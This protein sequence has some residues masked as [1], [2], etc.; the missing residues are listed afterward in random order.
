MTARNTNPS[1]REIVVH[2]NFH[3][4]LNSL[5]SKEGIPGADMM[6][7]KLLR[8]WLK[9]NE[10]SLKR[11]ILSNMYRPQPL[12]SF[13]V[14]DCVRNVPSYID[15]L[16]QESIVNV[17]AAHFEPDF[18]NL[19]FAR[20]DRS[21]NQAASFLQAKAAEF[22]DEGYTLAILPNTSLIY[23]KFEHEKLMDIL[24]NKIQDKAVQ[25]LIA[26]ILCAPLNVTGTVSDKV[27]VGLHQRSVL[28]KMLVNLVLDEIDKKLESNNI[29]FV[30]LL[31]KTV[32]FA[33]SKAEAEYVYKLYEVSF[34]E[35]TGLKL[36]ND[37]FELL[38]LEE[39]MSPLDGPLSA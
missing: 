25:S 35:L 24:S 39:D 31:D 29:K 4:A 17:L 27:T 20:A 11:A 2:E 8:D 23:E 30:R 6:E 9:V 12:K 14:G 37:V 18:S 36:D 21:A 28:A 13:N 32:L 5:E 26:K 38:E 3:K 22:F 19:S 15:R 10:G 34:F 7:G 33:R 1:L 16:V